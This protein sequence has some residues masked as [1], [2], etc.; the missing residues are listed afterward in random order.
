MDMAKIVRVFPDSRPEVGWIRTRRQ[1]ANAGL[2]SDFFPEPIED[3]LI[4]PPSV[5]VS[6]WH[7]EEVEPPD[8]LMLELVRSLGQGMFGGTI[9]EQAEVFVVVS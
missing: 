5:L 2:R 8:L 7:D 3:R 1:A 4:L 6:N 9:E